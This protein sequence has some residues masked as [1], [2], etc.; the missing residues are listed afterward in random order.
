[1]ADVQIEFRWQRGDAARWL[2]LDPTLGPG[3]PGLEDDT[4]RFKIGDGFNPWSQLEYFINKE[5]T[6]ALINELIED[7][8]G[9]TFD[10]RIGD[11]NDLATD[12]KTTIVG[13]INSVDTVLVPLRSLYNNAKAG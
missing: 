2:E 3:E 9:G 10:P 11:L 7:I 13:S 6:I 8:G 12:V 5:G 1:M 4:G